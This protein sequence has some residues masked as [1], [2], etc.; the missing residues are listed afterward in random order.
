[1]TNEDK[2]NAQRIAHF[3]YDPQAN[4]CGQHLKKLL[5]D[6][7]LYAIEET[8]RSELTFENLAN[9]NHDRVT[10]FG[11]GIQDWS[12]TDWG[13]AMAGEAGEACNLVKKMR[14]GDA[15]ELSAVGRELADTVIYAD[16]LAQRLGISLAEFV[17][18]KFNEVSEKRGSAYFI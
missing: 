6:V 17:R 3:F 2:Q 5:A 9:A 15:V 11:H 14:R 12:P 7:A 16:L 4:C 18:L 13:C 10:V 1:M 8:H